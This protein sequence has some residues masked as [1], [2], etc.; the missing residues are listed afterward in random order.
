SDL[1]GRFGIDLIAEKIEGER[2]VVDLLDFDVRFG[3][4]FLFAPPRPLRPEGTPTGSAP[5]GNGQEA[6]GTEKAAAAPSAAIDPPPRMSG[7][8]ALARRA[9]GPG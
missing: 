1:L 7:N 9:S 2:A 6:N 5:T 4:G 8:A 3:Q